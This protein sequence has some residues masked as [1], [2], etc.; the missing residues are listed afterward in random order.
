MHGRARRRA[1]VAR[2]DSPTPRESEV[3]NGI[4]RGWSNQRVADALGMGDGTV[5]THLKPGLRGCYDVM[6]H[7]AG[8][9]DVLREY[10]WPRTY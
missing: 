2:L 10:A 6:L 4:A 5:K 9:V 1:A 3:L 8:V 7:L